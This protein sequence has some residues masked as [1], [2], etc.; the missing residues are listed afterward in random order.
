[1]KRLFAILLVASMRLLG[2]RPKLAVHNGVHVR[3]ADAKTYGERLDRHAIGIKVSGF[4]NLLLG[5]LRHGVFLAAHSSFANRVLYVV[6]G[7]SQ[8]QMVRSYAKAVIA[9]VKNEK[10]RI[11]VAIVDAPRN[12]RRLSVGSVSFANISAPTSANTRSGSGPIPAGSIVVDSVDILPE[13]D[14]HRSYPRSNVASDRAVFPA[15]VSSSVG[16]LAAFANCVKWGVRHTT[17]LLLSLSVAYAQTQTGVILPYVQGQFFGATGAPL[18]NGFV[19]TYAAGTTTPL[20]TYSNSALTTA[21]QNPIRLNS[22][23]RPQSNQGVE[24]QI[25][26]RPQA[27]RVLVYASG[28]GNLCNGVV[29]G[30]LISTRDD[31]TA[32]NAQFADDLAVDGDVTVSDQL[33]STIATGTA[34]VVVT[35]TTPVDNLT[36]HPEAYNAAGTQRTNVQHVFG[37][38]ALVGGTASVTL[39]G[40]AV[41]SG[42]NNY[43]C[44][45]NDETAAAAV[46]V[47]RVSASNF[48]L[49]GTTTDTIAYHCV[50]Y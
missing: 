13:S 50:G 44:N 24:V 42:T 38:V 21:N 34:P 31:V 1:M 20:A 3:V 49:A 19:C 9:F 8:K 40:A 33:I 22:A 37:T 25:F 28:T 17:I 39:T 26:I 6:L 47:V 7:C 15:L 46:R 12:A 10:R 30:A 43:V 16:S 45:A 5:K 48:T 35:S 2:M 36:G 11:E 32:Y 41:F 27:Y 14:F 18:A 29:V 23:G 4:K